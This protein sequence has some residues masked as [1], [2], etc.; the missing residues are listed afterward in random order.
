MDDYNQYVTAVNKIFDY[1]EKMKV[2][3]SN[4]DNSNYIDNIGEFKNVVISKADEIKKPPT[5]KLEKTSAELLE[6]QRVAEQAALEDRTS[7]RTPTPE[8]PAEAAKQELNYMG[9]TEELA[10][11]M[12]EA[13][14]SGTDFMPHIGR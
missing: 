8:I 6:E 10:K 4:T 14:L 11:P 7:H 9:T 5:I 12:R 3:W 2:G 1:L 13:P